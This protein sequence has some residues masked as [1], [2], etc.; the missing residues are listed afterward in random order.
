[1]STNTLNDI[2]ENLKKLV[3]KACSYLE[4]TEERQEALDEIIRELLRSRKVW[5]EKTPYYE[6]ALQQTWLYLC[7]NPEQ[8]NPERGTVTNWIN[9]H[10]KWQLLDFQQATW[11]EKLRSSAVQIA[12]IE[13][14]YTQIEENN[15]LVRPD[16][17]TI[18]E[19]TRRW[20]ETDATRELRKTHI[21]DRPDVNCQI[22]MLLRLPPETR[23]ETIART[24]NLSM[25]TAP[26]FYKREA[27]PRLQ[28]F[29]STEGYL[30]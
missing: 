3:A 18:L 9:N 5:R 11:K 27:L 22:L 20:I 10:L 17:L 4:G 8:Y 23:W 7:D 24:F 29:A 1:M 25:S 21:K 14:T 13:E 6:D 12:N 15:L 26:N 16:F 30:E 2:D 28:K 19:Q